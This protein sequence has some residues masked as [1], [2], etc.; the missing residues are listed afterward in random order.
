M[1]TRFLLALSFVTLA[2]CSKGQPK[3][4]VTPEPPPSASA[5]TEPGVPTVM[6]IDARGV[7]PIH[8]GMSRDEVEKLPHVTVEASE[9]VL[10]G[11]TT[12]T[13]N[14]MRDGQALATAEL[15]DNRVSRIRIESPDVETARGAKVSMTAEELEKIYGAGKV[16]SGEG[17]ICALFEAEPGVSFCFQTNEPTVKDWAELRKANPKVGRILVVGG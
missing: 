4:Q 12:P 5:P 7:G 9:I 2:A 16:I 1:V 6:H 3:P 17:N 13:L 10:E 14:V 11:M 15:E 8:L